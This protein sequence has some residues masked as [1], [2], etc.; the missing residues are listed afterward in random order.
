MYPAA[1]NNYA[2]Y[3]DELVLFPKISV[4][5]VLI[6]AGCLPAKEDGM[7]R[8]RNVADTLRKSLHSWFIVRYGFT[9]DNEV[10]NN[11]FFI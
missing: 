10:R 1:E 2:L 9:H 11:P 8:D 4:H 5:S 3:S 6:E 7:A